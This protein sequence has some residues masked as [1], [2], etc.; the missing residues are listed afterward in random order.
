MSARSDVYSSAQLSWE[1][2]AVGTATAQQ[3]LRNILACLDMPTLAR[4]EDR[5]VARVERHAG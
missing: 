2:G 4:P 1:I 3:H 5:Y